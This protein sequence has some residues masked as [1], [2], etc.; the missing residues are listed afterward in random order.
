MR[1]KPKAAK[2]RNV[3]ETV[4]LV[5]EGDAELVW[6]GHLKRLYVLRGAG[7]V[8]TLKNAHGKGAA[9]VVD[10]SIRQSRNAAFDVKAVLLDT[11]TD[12][13]EQ[14]KVLEKEAGVEI[15]AAVPCL[16]GLLLKAHGCRV[17]GRTSA[18][19]KS[20]FAK[21]FGADALDLKVYEQH[22]PR[23]FVDESRTQVPEI[24]QILRLLRA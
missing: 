22:F 10:V 19:L 9:H 20:D 3:A 1:G 17:T 13:T 4:L 12:W 6:L 18:R 23:E 21:R 16:E 8:V 15:V 24:D 11:D 5:G 14:I 2:K 7:L